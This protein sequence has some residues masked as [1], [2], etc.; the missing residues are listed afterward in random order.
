MYHTM[1]LGIGGCAVFDESMNAERFSQIELKQ[2]MRAALAQ[3]ANLA[4]YQPRV[5]FGTSEVVAKE[6]ITWW[7]HK[8]RGLLNPHNFFGTGGSCRLGGK[9][10]CPGAKVSTPASGCLAKGGV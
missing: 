1:S 9:D 3:Q 5:D 6:A 4:F 10:R 2:E 8:R 7:Q